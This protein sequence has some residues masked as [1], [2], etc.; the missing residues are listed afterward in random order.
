MPA[1]PVF[2]RIP[3]KGPPFSSSQIAPPPALLLALL[4]STTAT[5][6]AAIKLTDDSQGCLDHVVLILQ[7]MWKNAEFED[8]G[9]REGGFLRVLGN[10]SR[11]EVRDGTIGFPVEV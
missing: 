11:I 6:H 4:P 3:P 2:P 10:V 9:V 1:E 7:K 8:L 5:P